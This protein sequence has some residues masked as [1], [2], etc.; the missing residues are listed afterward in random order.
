MLQGAAILCV[1]GI[2]EHPH[3]IVAV[4][5]LPQTWYVIEPGAW[6]AVVQVQGTICAWAE[7]SAITEEKALLTPEQLAEMRAYLEIYLPR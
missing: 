3:H 5:M 4:P 1:A 2:G 7:S 6:H